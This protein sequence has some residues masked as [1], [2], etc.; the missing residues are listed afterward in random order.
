[1]PDEAALPHPTAEKQASVENQKRDANE[2]VHPMLREGGGVEVKKEKKK[3][4]VEE[5]AAGSPPPAAKK[6]TKVQKQER[7]VKTNHSITS[8]FTVKKT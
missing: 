8:F 1:V 2:L 5:P 3:A 7:L 4:K 6:L